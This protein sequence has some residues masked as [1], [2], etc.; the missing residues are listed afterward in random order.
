MRPRYAC[1]GCPAPRIPPARRR[2]PPNITLTQRARVP[3]RF[4]DEHVAPWSLGNITSGAQ[5]LDPP[6]GERQLFHPLSLL[7]AQASDAGGEV[8]RQEI[9]GHALVEGNRVQTVGGASAERIRIKVSAVRAR[10]VALKVHDAN[11][12]CVYVDLNGHMLAHL[13]AF[14]H[15]FN[16]FTCMHAHMYMMHACMH[17]YILSSIHT[18][19]GGCN[20]LKAL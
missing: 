4:S 8:G 16:I 10:A 17:T 9:A 13:Y 2:A 18:S 7:W 11:N 3:A 6:A 1:G 20:R 14:T 12:V 5:L 19:I 15:V